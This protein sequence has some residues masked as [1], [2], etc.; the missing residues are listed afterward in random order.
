M[1]ATPVGKAPRAANGGHSNTEDSVMT[2][3]HVSRRGLLAAATGAAAG[4]TAPYIAPTL[5]RALPPIVQERRVC[6]AA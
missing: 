2:T 1:A 6:Q 4:L 3:R 5:P